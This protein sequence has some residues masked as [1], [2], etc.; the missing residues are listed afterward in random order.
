MCLRGHFLSLFGC[1]ADIA[2]VGLG[3]KLRTDGRTEVAL[4]VLHD[5]FGLDGFR[6]IL[7]LT[8]DIVDACGDAQRTCGSNKEETYRLTVGEG[9]AVGVLRE[10]AQVCRI[11]GVADGDVRTDPFCQ[12]FG[13]GYKL[14]A[15]FLAE[16]LLE[17]AAP[18]REHLVGDA[19]GVDVFCGKGI[20]LGRQTGRTDMV[21]EDIVV[22]V[23]NVLVAQGVKQG[24]DIA[25]TEFAEKAVKVGIVAAALL[26]QRT[27]QSKIIT[28]FLAEAAGISLIRESGHVGVADAVFASLAAL[29][30]GSSLR[31]DVRQVVMSGRRY[32]IEV[33]GIF[34]TGLMGEGNGDVLASGGNFPETVASVLAGP[35]HHIAVSGE[36]GATACG[37]A[38]LLFRRIELAIVVDLEVDIGI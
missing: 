29:V 18:G 31:T 23:A 5:G 27:D 26:D 25:L 1:E 22:E 11:V 30:V 10:L 35:Y 19:G 32:E 13:I 8:G 6:G 20:G 7:H 3:R 28:G 15:L 17:I 38:G 2:P 36:D 14:F 34:F 4:L 37:I 24:N 16:S 9:I 12:E 21:G 33:I